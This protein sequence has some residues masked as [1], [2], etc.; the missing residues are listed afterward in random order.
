MFGSLQRLTHTC[1]SQGLGPHRVCQQPPLLLPSVL[2][3]T[4]T[5][6]GLT[7]CYSLDLSEG[8]ALKLDQKFPFSIMRRIPLFKYI[9]GSSAE[10]RAA[11]SRR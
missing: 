6:V 11:Q 1:A 8:V 4:P 3:N 10:R 5:S 7:Y 9:S 2:L